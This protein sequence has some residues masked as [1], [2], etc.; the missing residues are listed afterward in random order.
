MSP[1]SMVDQSTIGVLFG[2]QAVLGKDV[3]V[4]MSTRQA[5]IFGAIFGLV[6]AIAGRLL[7]R[8]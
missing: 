1:G 6:V 8:R 3:K 7:R 4:I 2:P 5:L